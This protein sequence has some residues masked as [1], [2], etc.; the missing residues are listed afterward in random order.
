MWELETSRGC[1]HQPPATNSDE[2]LPLSPHHCARFALTQEL[3]HRKRQQGAT[4]Q[5]AKAKKPLGL[6]KHRNVLDAR[7]IP[8]LV[9]EFLE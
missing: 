3:K 2:I 6:A 8:P 4:E 1:R 5:A 7:R 9:H